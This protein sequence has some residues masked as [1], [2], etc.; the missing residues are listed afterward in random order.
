MLFDCVR[1]GRAKKLFRIMKRTGSISLPN[2]LKL[3]LKVILGCGFQY[4]SG[5]SHKYVPSTPKIRETII[6]D[7]LGLERQN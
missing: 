7:I 5:H 3:T 6:F 4:W 1:S 2:S